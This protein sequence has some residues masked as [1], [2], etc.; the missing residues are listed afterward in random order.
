[1]KIAD[2]RESDIVILKSIKRV[3]EDF[4][5]NNYPDIYQRVLDYVSDRMK[6]YSFLHK[7]TCYIFGI[8][9][10]PVCEICGNL[11]TKEFTW[12]RRFKDARIKTCSKKCYYLY[13]ARLRKETCLKKYGVVNVSK[14][15][16]IKDKK[17]ETCLTNYGVDNPSKNQLIQNKKIQTNL[18]RY[19]SENAMQSDIIKERL[20]NA[21]IEKYGVENP[22]DVEEFR[23]KLINTN[24]ERTGYAWNLSNPDTVRK[25]RDTC[26]KKYGVDW[27]TRVE[28]VKKRISDS[29]RI[30]AIKKC[31]LK[32]Q[33]SQYCIPLF[34]EKELLNA[35]DGDVLKWKCKTCNREINTRVIPSIFKLVRCEICHKKNISHQEMEITKFLIDE[36]KITD[37][38]RNVRDILS[39]GKEIDIYIPSK[40]I[41]IECDGLYWHSHS[42][43]REINDSY[44][45]NKTTECEDKGIRLIHIFENEWV[46]KQDI[47]RSRLLGILGKCPTT[48]YARKCIVKEVSY[49][50]SI[51]FLN[52]NHLQGFVVSKYRIGLYHCDKLISLMTFGSYRKSL[53]RD[54]KEDEYELLRFCNK[55]NYRIPGAASKLLNYFIKTYH[56]KKIITYC[57]RRWSQGKLY[58]ELGFK[59]IRNTDP[60][61]WYI[62]DD[63]LHHRFEFRKSVL[64]DK[65]LKYDESKSELE[66]MADNGYSW[67]YDCGNKLYELNLEDQVCDGDNRQEK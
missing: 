47:V 50:D 46:N 6:S 32:Y 23:N 33:E 25:S 27:P 26:M 39:D 59:F 7:L 48:I 19:G 22:M 2:V 17:K 20:R 28:E 37:V 10:F 41:A 3:N 65:L 1:M 29:N 16:S 64:K 9:D 61:Y 24:L 66:N 5:K 38:L 60:S 34:T 18:E 14:L 11:N 12:D 30:A 57:D 43:A 44:H 67:I 51:K 56:P 31:Y 45:L 21:F 55:L 15:Q 42:S 52:K 53:G 63:E 40:N 58:D 54:Q 36:C 8:S 35:N 13:L 4:I 49:E 62:I